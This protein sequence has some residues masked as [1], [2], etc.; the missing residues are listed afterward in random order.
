MEKKCRKCDKNKP[1]ESFGKT[2][3]YRRNVC[4]TCK[5][6]HDKITGGE[7]YKIRRNSLQ[8]SN[9]NDPVHIPQFILTDCRAS[10]KKKKRP[11]NNLDREFVTLVIRNGCMYCGSRHLRMTLD[12]IDN[13]KAHSKD[14]VNPSCIRCN[15]IRGSMPYSAWLHIVPAVKSAAEIGLLDNWRE[16]PW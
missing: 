2:G 11:G 4:H 13:S 8:R 12:R 10:D 6:Q 15:Y 16:R 5:S 7:K 3:K 14:N 1:I 9:R